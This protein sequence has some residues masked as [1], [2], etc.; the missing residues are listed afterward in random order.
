VMRPLY[1]PPV[2]PELRNDGHRG[3]WYDK[4]CNQ[5]GDGW[6]MKSSGDSN[7]KL[8][9]IQSVS[10]QVGA[11]EALSSYARRM[12]YLVD[13]RGGEAVAVTARS[14]FVTG[15]GR[16]HP[17]ENGFAWHPTLGTPYLPGSSVKGLTRA[18]AE[19]EGV[20]EVGRLLGD[21][22]TAGAVAFLDAVPLSPVRL[23][24]DVLT[25][26]YANWTPDNPPGDWLSPTPVPF[27][28]AAPGWSML[29]GIVPLASARDG[30]AATVK[31][32]LIS[33]LEQCGAGAKTAV[34]YGHFQEDA[35]NPTLRDLRRECQMRKVMATPEGR[36]RHQLEGRTEEE[37]LQ[38][39]RKHL[40]TEQLTDPA[41]RQAFVR[42]VLDTGMVASW[43]RGDKTDKNTSHGGKKLKTYARLVLDAAAEFGLEPPQ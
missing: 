32:W 42:A 26:H 43:K 36:W 41:E 16:S 15:L 31:H 21:Q 33:A 25:P 5:W 22:D 20:A 34:G 23:E 38:A 27:L 37:I 4:F 28:V 7:P 39:V 3:L 24:A 2:Q 10:H 40:K 14:R 6:T 35:Q 19:M 8:N 17:V 12:F 9:W 29:C 11:S 13:A 1:R 18:W 30:D